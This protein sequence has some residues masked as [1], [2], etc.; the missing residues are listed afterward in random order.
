MSLTR[1][2]DS[3]RLE[4]NR[5]E[6]YTR[7]LT[8]G[9]HVLCTVHSFFFVR[10]VRSEFDV[11]TARARVMGLLNR[12]PS[13]EVDATV[14]QR[15]RLWARSTR[16]LEEAPCFQMFKRSELKM[17]FKSKFFCPFTF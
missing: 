16:E 8:A 13:Y 17:S 4:S 11:P 7:R 5:F 10:K 15:R 1:S 2:L 6:T 3:T 14:G 9:V 12:M